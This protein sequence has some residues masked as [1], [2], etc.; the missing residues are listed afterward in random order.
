MENT[1][2]S[3]LLMGETLTV[4]YKDDSRDNFNL[5]NIVKACVG[6]ANAGGGVVLA[7][8]NDKGE[9][10][11][12]KKTLEKGRIELEGFIRENTDPGLETSVSHI[13]IGD[14]T[15]V[16]IDISP[17]DNVT[18][19]SSGIFYK[20]VINSKGE[21]CNNIMRGDDILRTIIKLSKVDLSARILKSCTVDDLDFDL[22]K[23]TAQDILKK[24]Q[25]PIDVEIF[26]KEP[27]DILKT[28]GLVVDNNIT[29][30]ALL[31]FGIPKILEEKIPSH[32]VK[33]QMFSN[34]G[35]ILRNEY[36]VQ[37]IVRLMPFL[38]KQDIF[39]KNSNE[40][41]IDGKSHYIPEYVNDALREAI[42]NAFAHRDYTKTLGIQIQLYPN[43][44]S[45]CSAGGFLE[46][47]SIDHLLS[48]P[49]Q[50]RNRLLANAMMRLKLV[51]SSGRGIDKIFYYQAL[52]GRAS[53]DYFSSTDEFVKVIIAGGDANLE[54]C[55]LVRTYNNPSIVE[56]LILNTLFYKHSLSVEDISKEIQQ[57]VSFTR[58]ILNNMFNKRWI[59]PLNKAHEIFLLN[60][61]L[62]H[63]SKNIVIT[64]ST[65]IDYK[66]KILNTLRE[67]P[68]LS[69]VELA[70]AIG[71]TTDQTY[72]LLN[73]LRDSG[74]I[75]LN[76]KK[77]ELISH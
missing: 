52:Y 54:F 47:I 56:M 7:G 13:K 74:E 41:I 64:K 12:S 8:I 33:L 9:I 28:L 43:E 59:Q 32:F 2:I 27:I 20:R 76:G 31:L 10:V 1:N 23:E 18:S 30:A 11:G 17:E 71:I 38:L 34:S 67:H 14:K 70:K 77:W 44:L 19:T 50:P 4:E 16:K 72:R 36:Y 3:S 62:N 5:D 24:S 69:R 63:S 51:E 48:T 39:N 42:S 60:D 21:P 68:S 73:S 35:E 40:I 15:I 25:D 37:P 75:Q 65:A 66:I 58:T 55:R 45:I 49:P 53:P 46:G 61:P 22:I 6:M 29:E 26:S 57:T